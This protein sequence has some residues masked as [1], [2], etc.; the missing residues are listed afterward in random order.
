MTYYGFYKE[1]VGWIGDAVA[2]GTRFLSGAF[3]LYAGLYL[4]DFKSD[5]ELRQG[6]AT[7]LKNGAHGV[8][9]YGNVTDNTLAILRDELRA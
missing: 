6:I 1:K 4:P 9:F 3:P 7:A 2:E 8:S 5:D